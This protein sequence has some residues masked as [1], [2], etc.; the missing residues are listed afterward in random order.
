MPKVGPKRQITLLASHCKQLG[1]RPGDEVEIFV[2]NGRLPIVRK[3]K[4]TAQR[5]LQDIKGDTSVTDRE[6]LEDALTS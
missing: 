2:S 3:P 4:G 5:L 1:I 6:S